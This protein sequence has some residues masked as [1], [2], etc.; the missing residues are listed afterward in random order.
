MSALPRPPL[1]DAL[2]SLKP[3]VIYTMADPK[4][5]AS[6][7]SAFSQGAVNRFRWGGSGLLLE[8]VMGKQDDAPAVRFTCPDGTLQTVC[9]CGVS[10]NCRHVL[11]AAMT[12]ARVVHDAKFHRTDLP[13]VT[14]AKF[15]QQLLSLIHI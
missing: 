6:A 15:R 7:A 5:I 4:A 3:N 9:D 1:L 12:I 14:V 13:A 8:A 10:G 2:A 11:S